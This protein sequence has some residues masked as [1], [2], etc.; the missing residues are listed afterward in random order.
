MKLCARL[1]PVCVMA[2]G[3]I[4]AAGLGAGGLVA[5]SIAIRTGALLTSIAPSTKVRAPARKET[6]G[7]RTS[8]FTDYKNAGGREGRHIKR[9]QTV[10]VIC[11]IRGFKVQDGDIW[12]Y[13]IASSPWDGKYY[14]S[15]DDFYNDGR[16]SGS[17]RGTPLVDPKVRV[18]SK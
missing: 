9:Y 10:K 7:V 3:S 11:R 2:A 16:T 13:R 18:C 5:P 1:S 15:A 12:W 17:L 14:A 8:T 6:V 4:L